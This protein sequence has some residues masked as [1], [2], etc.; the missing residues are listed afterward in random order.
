M[1]ISDPRDGFFYP[2]LTLMTDSYCEPVRMA[3][4]AL[5]SHVSTGT[6]ISTLMSLAY[7]AKYALVENGLLIYAN[8]PKTLHLQTA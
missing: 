7:N 2:T 6:K 1:P 4:R 3:R 8:H 5:Q